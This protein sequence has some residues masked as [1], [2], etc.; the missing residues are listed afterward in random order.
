MRCTIL[1][2]DGRAFRRLRMILDQ[3]D[4]S[5]PASWAAS[6]F[7]ILGGEDDGDE[8]RI[9]ASQLPRRIYIVRTAVT[10]TT[11]YREPVRV[12]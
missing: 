2:K 1:S 9:V 5:K 4:T 3:T 8:P 7:H 11:V 6:R 12:R 10:M